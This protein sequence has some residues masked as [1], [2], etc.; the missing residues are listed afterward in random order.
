VSDNEKRIE[1][2]GVS[3]LI[4]CSNAG[5]ACFTRYHHF[6][7]GQCSLSAFDLAAIISIHKPRF[8]GSDDRLYTAGPCSIPKL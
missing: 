2:E 3:E 7:T 4:Q 6:H 5:G 8:A 1:K